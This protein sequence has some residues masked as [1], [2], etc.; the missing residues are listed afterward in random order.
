MNYVSILLCFVNLHVEVTLH[1]KLKSLATN[2]AKSFD[3][4]HCY[5]S[6]HSLTD[7][8]LTANVDAMRG[9]M[10]FVYCLNLVGQN[11][12]LLDA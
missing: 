2:H 7:L 4:Y 11:L 1:W 5:N 6:T 3:E 8:K 12:N 9:P 10:G